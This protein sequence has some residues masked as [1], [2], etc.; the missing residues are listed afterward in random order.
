MLDILKAYVY[1]ELVAC[2]TL[3]LKLFRKL[4]KFPKRLEVVVSVD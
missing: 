3:I 1:R 2:K 4:R